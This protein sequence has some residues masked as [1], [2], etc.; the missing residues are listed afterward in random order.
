MLHSATYRSVYKHVTILHSALHVDQ[1]LGCYIV[2]HYFPRFDR[3][4]VHVVVVIL[5]TITVSFDRGVVHV[6][7][8]I[9]S[10]I[11]V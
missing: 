8:V 5:Y 9:L 2:Y 7:V 6:L 1:C 3:G 10:T 11:T 4:E